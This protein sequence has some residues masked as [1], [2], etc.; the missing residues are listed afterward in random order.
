MNNIFLYLT[1]LRTDVLVEEIFFQTIWITAEHWNLKWKMYLCL[2]MIAGG[3]VR[4]V[5]NVEQSRGFVG[6]VRVSFVF[7]FLSTH[8]ESGSSWT[9]IVVCSKETSMPGW[10]GQTMQGKGSLLHGR[11]K[12]RC[13]RPFWLTLFL[14]SSPSPFCISHLQLSL[15]ASYYY[16]TSDELS[17]GEIIS[18]YIPTNF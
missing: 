1:D 7:V 3:N 15:Y 4:K 18:W 10:V 5:C 12:K 8:L 11:C 6:I 9:G 13:S 17:R 14:H 16:K 2:Y